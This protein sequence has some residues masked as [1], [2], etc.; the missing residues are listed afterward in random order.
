MNY[1]RSR[2]LKRLLSI[3]RR[4][5]PDDD[6]VVEAEPPPPP[7]PVL[8]APSKPAWRCFSY[9]EVDQATN[10]FHPGN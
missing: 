10:G 3:G 6:C 8:V 2:S 7:P 1:L 9:E 4:S 5:N